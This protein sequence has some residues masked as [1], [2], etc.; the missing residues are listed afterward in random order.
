ML[1]KRS[2]RWLGLLTSWTTIALSPRRCAGVAVLAVLE[3]VIAFGRLRSRKHSCRRF[4]T[5]GLAKGQ[6]RSRNAKLLL[7]GV[8]VHSLVSYKLAECHLA[9]DCYIPYI[10]ATTRIRQ[11]AGLKLLAIEDGGVSFI[12]S[13]SKPSACDV[14]VP[15]V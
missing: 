7:L 8:W 10:L 13:T 4:W 11:E 15:H 5:S 14:Y 6:L 9:A 2:C 3:T 1:R 12:I